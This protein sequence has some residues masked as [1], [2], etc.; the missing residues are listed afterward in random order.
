MSGNL[1]QLQTTA[2]P[3]QI[4]RIDGPYDTYGRVISLQPSGFHLIRGL[5]HKKPAQHVVSSR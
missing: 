5:G 3:G 4:M 1:Y 2:L